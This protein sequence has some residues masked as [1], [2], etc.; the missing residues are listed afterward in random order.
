MPLGKAPNSVFIECIGNIPAGQA[1]ML[2]KD[3]F[4]K[5]GMSSLTSIRVAVKRYAQHGLISNDFKALQR[6]SNGETAIYIV[7]N[8]DINSKSLEFKQ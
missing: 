8:S 2:T 3:D 6:K 5:L 1:W 7:R 4:A